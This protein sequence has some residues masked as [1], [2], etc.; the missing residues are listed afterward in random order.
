MYIRSCMYALN[1]C[2]LLTL[3]AVQAETAKHLSF[4]ERC[5]YASTQQA[6]HGLLLL[7]TQ[8]INVGSSIQVVIVFRLASSQDSNH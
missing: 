3:K 4:S 6:R 8:G 1:V 5:Q 7:S 2:C